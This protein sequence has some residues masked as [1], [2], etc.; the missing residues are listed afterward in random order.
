MERITVFFAAIIALFSLRHRE[1][2]DME[3]RFVDSYNEARKS[4]VA[5]GWVAPR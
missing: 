2:P 3:Q 1:K 4:W 5:K